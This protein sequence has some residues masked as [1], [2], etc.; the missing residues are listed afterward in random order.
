MIRINNLHKLYGSGSEKMEVLRGLSF[1]LEKG[2][3]MCVLGP[4][5]SGKSTLLNICGGIESIDEGRVEVFGQDLGSMQKKELELYRRNDLGFVFQ[6]YNLLS[7]LNV[8]ENI[9]VGKYL[10]QDPLEI[11]R[12]IDDLDLRE[13]ID[14]YPN[15]ISGGQ[16]QRT[17]IGR[18]MVKRPKLLICDEPTGAL[19]YESAR[20]VLIL[21]EKLNQLYGSTV[22]IATHNIQIAKMCDLILSIHNGNIKSLVENKEKIPAREVCW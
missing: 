7:H 18:A 8:Y 19:D 21:I 13:H 16:A 11:D 4:S 14:K 1:E 12:L 15:E 5:G 20:E 10:A 17:S 6:F 22:I 9:E 3:I 2:K